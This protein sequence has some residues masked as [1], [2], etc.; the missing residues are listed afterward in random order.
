MSLS[1]SIS[2]TT[3]RQLVLHLAQCKWTNNSKKR[4]SKKLNWIKW[5]RIKKKFFDLSM[6]IWLHCNSALTSIFY[7]WFNKNHLI[8]F[9]WKLET[10]CG[11]YFLQC[12]GRLP[13]GKRP[14]QKSHDKFS[15]RFLCI[16]HGFLKTMS[17][18]AILVA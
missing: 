5:V 16:F 13:R 10:I 8:V 15:F 1:L 9:L 11:Q 12:D 17:V 4:T 7:Q 6:P 18:S 3:H 14:F 2:K